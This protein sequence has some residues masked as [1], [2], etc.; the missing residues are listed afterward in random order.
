[1][2]RREFITLLGGAAVWPMAA[3]AQPGERMRRIGV[4][5]LR[6]ESDREVQSRLAI[7]RRRLE[8]LGWRDGTNVHFDYRWTGGDSSRLREYADDLVALNSDIILTDST[9][10]VTALQKAT[11]SIPIV[12]V[13]AQNP[14]GSGFVASMARPGG[15]I[16]GFVA[17]EP[18]MGG[19]WVEMLKELAPTVERI[20]FLH[21]PRTH[22]GQY[23]QS[24]RSAARA[25]SLETTAAEFGNAAEIESMV[26]DVALRPNGAL[27]VLPDTST[28][29]HAE[30][31]VSLAARHRLPAIYAYRH[32]IDG[33]G[34]AYYGTDTMTQFQQAAFYVDRIL[35]GE[36]PGDLPVQ[37]PTRFEFVI[38]LKTAKALGLEIPPMLLARADE[39]IE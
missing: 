33:G 10:A 37:A 38:N 12:F 36:K 8:E 2:R 14:V 15:N 23:T 13:N 9:P 29:L 34:L 18:T 7:F 19:K 22:T 32:F 26:G 25:L 31:I 16:T 1:M 4:L 17:F 3:R 30:L 28:N 35:K 20:A 27:L 11:R 5:K 6:R 24:I 21:N 39:V